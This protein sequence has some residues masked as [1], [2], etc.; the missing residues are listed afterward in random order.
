MEMTSETI[1]D[2]RNV[3]AS[4]KAYVQILKRRVE[5]NEI[6]ESLEYLSKI[7]EKSDILT[8]MLQANTSQKGK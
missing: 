8:S 1:H 6:A 2:I 5:K 7:D 4:I 3:V